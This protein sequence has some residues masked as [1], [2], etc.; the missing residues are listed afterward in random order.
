[1]GEN[2]GLVRIIIFG[3]IGLLVAAAFIGIV[4]VAVSLKKLASEESKYTQQHIDCMLR[5]V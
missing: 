4:L 5:R 2:G 1:M 3:V